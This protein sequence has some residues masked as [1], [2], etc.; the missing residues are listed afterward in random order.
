MPQIVAK[1]EILLDDTGQIVVNGV[2]DNRLLAYG[3]LEVARDVI[4]E[5]ATQ[6]QRKI[7]VPGPGDLRALG[8][9]IQ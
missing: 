2:I 3:L 7:Q 9:S 6:M 4:Q 8:K 5:R 1:L